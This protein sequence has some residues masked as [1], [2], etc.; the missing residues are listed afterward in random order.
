MVMFDNSY[1][2][3]PDRFYRRIAPE[4]APSPKVMLFNAA[5]AEK[6]GIQDW[7]AGELSGDVLPDGADPIAQVYAGHQFGGWNPRLGDGR[8]VLLGET[9]TDDGRYDIQL[10]GAGRT[11]YSRNGDGRAWIGPALREYLISEFMAACG[12]P[13]TR[14]LAV[15]YTGL[16]VQREQTY[17]GAVLTRVARSH[18]RVG[19]FQYFTAEGDTD[20]VSLLADHVRARHFPEAKPG[21]AGL[22]AAI[23]AAQARL[24]AHWM[25]LGFVHG[26]M[27]TDN[28]AISG[29]TIDY[30][31]CA[32]IDGFSPKAVYSSIDDNGR[33]AYN[34]QPAVAHWNLAQLGSSFVAMAEKEYGGEEAAIE[35]LTVSLNRFPKLYEAAYLNVFA[36]KIGIETPR[37]GDKELV[38][39]LLSLMAKDGA[40]FTNT[41]RGLSDG[42]ARDWFLDRDAFDRWQ[43]TWQARVADETGA[44]ERMAQANPVIIPRTH[45]IE[46]AIQAALKGDEAPAQRLARC[47]A[48]PFTLG[49]DDQAL[50]HPP[51]ED[52]MVTRT[53]C[54]T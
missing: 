9:V 43:Q 24:I 10:K 54:G 25:G 20:A 38:S 12:V 2:R 14:A 32:F 37:D 50:T 4:G 46:E 49:P 23:I 30:G 34:Q 48:T 22:F 11:P 28:M 31:P 39:S 6:L 29:E 26:V 53:F 19:T 18:I 15:T 36:R 27:N 51:R 44:A 5:L 35:M 47:L 17:P 16:A 1:A 21:I 40:D 3:L 42:T 41:F 8:A 45:R 13:T 33:Y 7:G 52:E